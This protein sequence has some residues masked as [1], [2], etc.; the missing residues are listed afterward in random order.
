MGISLAPHER[1]NSCIVWVV[2]RVCGRDLVG[3]Q[4]HVL[5]VFILNSLDD[6]LFLETSFPVFL[7]IR[8]VAHG[9]HRA[10]IRPVEVDSLFWRR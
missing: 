9:V 3:V 5:T 8:F 4:D 2:S 7:L 1:F 10:P 6:I